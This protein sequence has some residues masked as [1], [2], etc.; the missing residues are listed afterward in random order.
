MRTIAPVAT[1]LVTLISTA[2]APAQCLGPVCRPFGTGL[3][4]NVWLGPAFPPPYYYGYGY[5]TVYWNAWVAPPVLA[6]PLARPSPG[7]FE[8]ADDVPTSGGVDL[9]A[10]RKKLARDREVDEQADRLAKGRVDEATRKGEFV[11][12]EPG[13]AVVKRPDVPPAKIPDAPL[14]PVAVAVKPVEKL[15]IDPAGLAR[16][17]LLKGQ[18]AFDAGEL[19]RATERLAAAVAADPALTAAHF[20]LAQVRLARGQYSEAV[21]AIRDGMKNVRDWPSV[22]VRVDDLYAINPKRLATDVADLKAALE[23]SPNDTTL[24]FLYAHHLWF[25]GDRAAATEL[26]RKL[27]GKVKESELVEPFLTK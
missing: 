4:V 1:L 10:L 13:K 21:D 2:P 12:F 6:V 20:K 18:E 23:A 5:S 19:G 11:V 25:S 15:P 7:V 24:T 22:R 8:F 16:F 14:K 17:Q 27:D 9:A 26:F 3:R